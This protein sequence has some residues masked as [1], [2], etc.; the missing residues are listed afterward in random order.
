MQ[1]H[2]NGGVPSRPPALDSLD[3]HAQRTVLLELVV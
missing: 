1:D 2:R 3:F